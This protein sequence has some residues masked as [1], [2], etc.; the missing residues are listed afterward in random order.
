M[1]QESSN[2]TLQNQPHPLES[3][4]GPG[5]SGENGGPCHNQ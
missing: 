4:T 5:G 2:G 3:C 1:D